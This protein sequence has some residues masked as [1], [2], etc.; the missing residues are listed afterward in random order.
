MNQGPSWVLLMK[1]NGGEKSHATVP[2]KFYG[3]GTAK[4][5]IWVYVLPNLLCYHRSHKGTVNMVCNANPTGFFFHIFWAKTK[6]QQILLTSNPG[7]SEHRDLTSCSRILTLGTTD[8]IYCA[9]KAWH[10]SLSH[11]KWTRAG[12]YPPSPTHTQLG[13]LTQLIKLSDGMSINN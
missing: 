8:Y 11:F 12:H 13:G 3:C 7:I 5:Q 9:E 2:W 10:L 1:K 6:D 4:S